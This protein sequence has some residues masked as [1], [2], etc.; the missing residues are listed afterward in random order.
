MPTS[1]IFI[2][3][4]P[5]RRHWDHNTDHIQEIIVTQSESKPNISGNPTV[6]DTHPTKQLCEVE[7]RLYS[8]GIQ[9]LENSIARIAK[10]QTDRIDEDGDL[11]WWIGGDDLRDLNK[12][13]DDLGKAI[14]TLCLIS[15]G[16]GYGWEVT[17]K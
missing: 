4:H 5:S 6:S 8:Q 2:Y 16:T 12:A 11:V 13:I 3:E 1:E 17:D 15:S 14:M 7:Y 9:E 10:I